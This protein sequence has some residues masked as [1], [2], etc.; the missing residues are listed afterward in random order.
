[1]ESCGGISSP[2][3]WTRFGIVNIQAGLE[4]SGEECGRREADSDNTSLKSTAV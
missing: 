3:I 2:L 1:V 4:L